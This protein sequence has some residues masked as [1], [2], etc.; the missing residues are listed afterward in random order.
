MDEQPDAE[1]F[2][3]DQAIVIMQFIIKYI[4]HLFYNIT[5]ASF[6][7]NSFD[8]VFYPLLYSPTI[9]WLA[10]TFSYSTIKPN[11]TDSTIIETKCQT[12]NKPKTRRHLPERPPDVVAQTVQPEERRQQGH[13]QNDVGHHEADVATE[14]GE[15][16]HQI[17]RLADDQAQ[18]DRGDDVA[19]Q[20]A[21][22]VSWL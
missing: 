17:G 8:S 12:S 16:A 3:I 21:A 13:I 11:H 18:R 22:I 10:L 15:D 4:L 5:I 9:I 6:P 2:G 14:L 20:I 7:T 1:G 19:D